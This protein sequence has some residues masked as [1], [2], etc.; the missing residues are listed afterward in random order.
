MLA[1][2]LPAFVAFLTIWCGIALCGAAETKSRVPPSDATVELDSLRPGVWIHTSYYTYPNGSRFS[3]NGLVVRDGNGL[4]LIDTAWGERLTVTL[5]E[6]I[7]RDLALP[8][9]RAVVTHAHGDRSAGAD[10]LRD[11]G[12]PVLAHPETIQRALGMGLPPPSDSLNG[13]TGPG[14]LTRLGSVE[15]YYPGP[16]HS[17]ENLMVWVPAARVLFGGCAVRPGDATTLG[18]TAHADVKA[19]PFAIQRTLDRYGSAEVVVPGH[20]SKGGPDLLGHTL[21]LLTRAIPK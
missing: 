1:R 10:V 7:Q 6:Q 9:Q 16:G 17:P 5:L 18:N 2:G 20:G 3:S 12:I 11:R 19:W 15:V 13:L 14:T 8:V 4:T 21:S